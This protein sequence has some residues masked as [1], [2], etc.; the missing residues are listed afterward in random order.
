[1]MQITN[2]FIIILIIISGI[3]TSYA[4]DR[5]GIIDE[6]QPFLDCNWVIQEKNIINNGDIPGS[7]ED[8][9]ED[10][11]R[12]NPDDSPADKDRRWPYWKLNQYVNVNGSEGEAYAYGLKDYPTEFRSKL[13]DKYV[14]GRKD[15]APRPSG[16]KGYAGIDCSGLVC[17]AIGSAMYDTT[18]LKANVLVRIEPKDVKKGDFLFNNSRRHVMVFGDVVFNGQNSALVYHAVSWA[19]SNDNPGW[20]CRQVIEEYISLSPY[21][22]SFYIW[23]NAYEVNQE[24]AHDPY[25]IFPY[26]TPKLYPR[27]TIYVNSNNNICIPIWIVLKSKLDIKYE[28]VSATLDST[29]VAVECLIVDDERVSVRYTPTTPISIGKH[30]YVVTATNEWDYSETSKKYEFEIKVGDTAP[31]PDDLDNDG[32]PD[33]WEDYYWENTEEE[34]PDGDPDSDG[35]NNYEEYMMATDPTKPQEKNKNLIPKQNAKTP[36]E[37]Y[38][39]YMLSIKDVDAPADPNIL[40]GPAGQIDPDQTLNYTVEFENV[41]EG[42]AYGV[43]IVDTFNS[44]FDTTTLVV[45]NFKRID[46]DT[47]TETSADFTYNFDSELRSLTVFVDTEGE[48][49]PNQGGKFDISIKLVDG[50]QVGTAVSNYAT[51]FFPS[52]PEETNTNT[53]VS[54]VASETNLQYTGPESFS[55]ASLAELSGYLTDTSSNSIVN[56]DVIFTIAGTS[57]TAKTDGSGSYFLPIDPLDLPAGEYELD[58]D[59]LGD[60]Y[61]YFPAHVSESINIVKKSVIISD[62]SQVTASTDFLTITTTVTDIQDYD[63]L[64]QQDEPKTLYLEYKTSDTWH[65]LSEAVLSGSSVTLSFQLPMPIQKTY[66]IRAKFNGD[67]RYGYEVSES[68]IVLSDT[69][70]ISSLYSDD[71]YLSHHEPTNIK[72]QVAE[73]AKVE[74][75]VYDY[76]YNLIRS[77]PF[78]SSEQGYLYANE[79]NG[80]SSSGCAVNTGTYIVLAV[81]LNAE[82]NLSTSTINVIVDNEDPV[83]AFSQPVAGSWYKGTVEIS[84]TALDMISGLSEYTLN[85]SSG[86]TWMPIL[87]STETVENGILGQWV[88][89]PE[90]NG[91]TYTLKLVATDFVGNSSTAT[92]TIYVDNVLPVANIQQPAAGSWCRSSVQIVGTAQDYAY[93]GTGFLNYALS[94]SVIPGNW[95]EISTSGVAVENG[96]LGVWETPSSANGEYYGIKLSVADKAGNV[97]ETTT[98]V[99]V[100]NIAPVTAL[101]EPISSEL[102]TGLINISGT[103]QDYGVLCSGLQ[104]YELTYSSASGSSVSITASQTPVENGLLGSWNTPPTANDELY[105][106]KL[107]AADVAGN[108]NETTVGIHIDNTPPVISNLQAR[109]ITSNSARICWNTDDLSDTNLAYGTVPWP[110]NFVV[111]STEN[112][113]AHAAVI[114]GLEIYPKRYYY[115]VKSLN[116][117]DMTSSSTGYFDTA[118][119]VSILPQLFPGV[120]ITSG[121]VTIQPIISNPTITALKLYIDDTL[122][123]TKQ[124]VAEFVIDTGYSGSLGLA[125]GVHKFMLRAIDQ[126]GLEYNRKFTVVLNNDGTGIFASN[127]ACMTCGES[128]GSQ[129]S[130]IDSISGQPVAGYSSYLSSSVVY[131]GALYSKSI[132]SG[133]LCVKPENISVVSRDDILSGQRKIIITVDIRNLGAAM[134][135][136]VKVRFLEGEAPNKSQIGEDKVINAISGNATMTA[137]AEKTIPISDSPAFFRFTIIADPDS[138][139]NDMNRGNNEAEKDV[140]ISPDGGPVIVGFQDAPVD[141]FSNIYVM[142]DEIS[143]KD[144]NDEQVDLNTEQS[145]LDMLE[146]RQ[147]NQP[148]AVAA[149][150]V[151]SGEYNG[152]SAKINSVVGIDKATKGVVNFSVTNPDV[153]IDNVFTVDKDEVVTYIVDFNL[154]ESVI[155]DG[156]NYIFAPSTDNIQGVVKHHS[157]DVIIDTKQVMMGLGQQEQVNCLIMNNAGNEDR[158][159]AKLV[160]NINRSMFILPSSITVASQGAE[161]TQIEFKTP[162]STRTFN[163]QD[164]DYKIL[165]SIDWP[166][167]FDKLLPVSFGKLVDGKFVIDYMRPKMDLVVGNPKYASNYL[168]VK[169]NTQFTINSKDDL[170]NAEDSLGLGVSSN[171]WMLS[172]ANWNEYTNNNPA[173][174][175]TF[176]S[177]FT[178]SGFDQG[179]YTLSCRSE[180]LYKNT[181]VIS[182]DI[183]IDNTPPFSGIALSSPVFSKNSENYVSD[184][185]IY[186]VADYDPPVGREVFEETFS[187]GCTRWVNVWGTWN[188]SNGEYYGT[189]GLSRTEATFPADRIV[190]ADVCTVYKDYG[191]W[192][193]G[194]LYGKYH[195]WAN[196]MYMLLHSNGDIELSILK[197][198]QTER[199]FAMSS[200]NPFENHRFRY[201]IFGENVKIFVDGDKYIDIISTAVPFL[202]GSAAFDANGQSQAKFDNLKVYTDFV[203]GCGTAQ[204]NMNIDNAGYN[205]YISPF[206]LN[207]EGRHSIKYYS[208]DNLGNASSEK[209]LDVV[210]DGQPPEIEV[211]SDNLFND[212]SNIYIFDESTFTVNAID[213][214]ITNYYLDENFEENHYKF[215]SL[216]GDWSIAGGKYTGSNGKTISVDTY[217]ADRIVETDVKTTSPGAD[218]WNVAW[219]YAKHTDSSNRIY[220]LLHSGGNIELTIILQGVNSRYDVQTSL[221]PQDL[222]N[223]RFEISGNN[224]KLYIDNELYFN[225][226]DAKISQLS[227]GIGYETMNCSAEFSNAKV[228]D[229]VEPSG[230]KEMTVAIDG[231]DYSSI[232]NHYLEENFTQNNHTFAEQFGNWHIAGG[233]YFGSNGKSLSVDTYPADRIVE[234]DVKTTSPGANSWDVAW[235][236]AKHTDSSNRIYALLHSGGNIELTITLQGAGS[237]YDVQSS[238]NPQDLHN[239]RF[240]ISGNNLKLYIDNELYFNVNDAKISQLSG[241]IGY[242]TMNCSAEFS[243][244]KV[245]DK[246]LSAL[247]FVGGGRHTI[248]YKGSDNVGNIAESEYIVLVDTLAPVSYMSVSQ[249]KYSANGNLY[250]TL[251]TLFTI[252]A[253]DEGEYPSNIKNTE[254]RIDND[255]WTN[256]A[257]PFTLSDVA[258][259]AHTVTYRSYDNGGNTEETKSIDVVVDNTPPAIVINS[260]IGGDIYVEARDMIN[261]SFNASDISQ[262]NTT[263]YMTLVECE[264]EPLIG[265]KVSVTTSSSIN[266]S[267]LPYYG[268]YTMTV[269]AGDY[270][271]HYASSTTA[272]FEVIWDTYTLTPTIDPITSP[273]SDPGIIVSG[274][275]ETDA[276]VH[277]KM[278]QPKAAMAEYTV[279]ASSDTYT[280]PITLANGDGVYTLTAKAHDIADNWSAESNPV[281]IVFT[282]SGILPVVTLITPDGGERIKGDTYDIQWNAVPYYSTDTITG[283]T[284]KYT[285]QTMQAGI[286]NFDDGDYVN[287]LN[288]N[289]GIWYSSNAIV[290]SEF[291]NAQDAYSNTGKS[292]QLDYEIPGQNDNGGFWTGIYTVPDMSTYTHVSLVVKGS[293][294]G[295]EFKVGLKDTSYNEVK[296]PV[297]DYLTEDVTTYWQKVTIPMSA[298]NGVNCSSLDNF[299]IS[300]DGISGT[301]SV[302]IDELR[303]IRWNAIANSISNAGDYIVNTAGLTQSE[304]SLVRVEAT[305]SQSRINYAESMDY[306]AMATNLAKGKTATAS[307]GQDTASLAVDGVGSTRWSSDASDPQ[308]YQVDI[309][310]VQPVNKVVLNWETAYGKAYTIDVSSNGVDW[311]TVYAT[312]NSAGGLENIEFNAVNARYVRMYGTER[313]TQ[314]GYSLW[315]FE[316]YFNIHKASVSAS[317]Q[318]VD[319]IASN[320]FDGDL[321]T[322]WSSDA[323]D[324]EWISIDFGAPVS[325][326][327]V[328]LFWETAY[329]ESY[330]ILVSN[331]GSN[332]TNAYSQTNGTGGTE[333]INV[334]SQSA[335]Y[336][337]IDGKQ[338]G[339]Q[340]GYSLWEIEVK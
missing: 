238:L 167:S 228:Y 154:N 140:A 93:G 321:G 73:N 279:I 174:G 114:D 33:W 4:R 173:V 32:L 163:G 22:S 127:I 195:D 51:V 171:S 187:T 133:D 262:A 242:E 100:E 157:F 257:S 105:T 297:K 72:Y 260:P 251:D 323:D 120:D 21:Y 162:S 31:N 128:Y 312:T 326:S 241:G 302:Y 175:Q 301:G 38:K 40:Y 311:T 119:N 288:A 324:T 146:T 276:T 130:G 141:D 64:H 116:R 81:A 201:E 270:L 290:S 104:G 317:S 112:V 59:Y 334:G 339:T 147:P 180:D 11:R 67:S 14:A 258:E 261:V 253:Q 252:T 182:S 8:D 7:K 10:D 82:N 61:F 97:C 243:N 207:G 134:L 178:L 219:V 245:Y 148:V 16:Y 150:I 48:I 294:G 25:T 43:Y 139:V 267:E 191:T 327:T 153:D 192:N 272:K 183:I 24:Q 190:E 250:V 42:I 307:S 6:I 88:T 208:V 98:T 121:V 204:A 118:F 84:G 65:A 240:E 63:L 69:Q 280:L 18:D 231:G 247:S 185:M 198:G 27:K 156:T 170:Y 320:A 211:I 319:L 165:Y 273:R 47:Q 298:F 41:G 210:V 83:T 331:D 151:P 222:H 117:L 99:R 132:Q 215:N 44:Y 177:E 50:I 196:C 144:S 46:Y 91:E 80:N 313:G 230:A 62:P 197:D 89:P 291:T 122:I 86:E 337:K 158:Y 310:T 188:V 3:G 314:W 53:I 234:T 15:E 232:L 330:D 329:G 309:G 268:F 244:A 332:W 85:Y 1:M 107:T 328:V 184:D 308:W 136:N 220:A 125:D 225:V 5:D 213:P 338:R 23:N 20:H 266:P 292:L 336:L 76:E 2:V 37:P 265:T 109:D 68:A 237:R 74:L 145:T 212:G 306:F 254:Y 52:A 142:F 340:W 56:Q 248:A 169:S 58:I 181:K 227:G 216:W 9:E 271:G 289:S 17:Y 106:L 318:G 255:T 90:A 166:S 115:N 131:L 286:D 299:S 264:C 159:C 35:L 77:F 333:R 203:V 70:A 45:S 29:P 199:Y 226:N 60:G 94:Y 295:E 54:V 283:I 200:L 164:T 304:R 274:S 172:G 149:G 36:I 108:T 236:Y 126:N 39:G 214:F 179:L 316:E 246:D 176:S 277:I 263:A 57:Y 249:P 325:F 256:Y 26:F 193:L 275:A 30:E 71:I 28:T 189:A 202:S 138:E 160:T 95:I 129:D 315:E 49:G 152:F 269:E 322:R 281:Q 235:V 223:F 221:N 282:R 102:F 194:W 135:D 303:F 229:R 335:R 111:I 155:A 287:N 161:L 66:P 124:S 101:S 224:L 143:L 92:I 55:C 305:D 285:D 259:G 296:L 293:Q 205:A 278:Y 209:N 239:F 78:V 168:F 137:I 300:F 34:G 12:G 233:K 217:P 87:S 284:L 79:W 103:A 19:Y 186:A 206:V 123:E 113:R 110:E 218:S 96:N 75:L 13:A